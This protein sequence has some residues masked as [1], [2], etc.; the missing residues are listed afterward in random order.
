MVR[1][2]RSCSGFRI[3]LYRTSCE[4]Q[5]N[6]KK[7]AFSVV[8]RCLCEQVVM[9]AWARICSSPRR[10][11]S[12]CMCRRPTNLLVGTMILRQ[13]RQQQQHLLLLRLRRLLRRRLLLLLQ[14]LLLLLLLLLPPPPPRLLL[15]LLLLLLLS[16]LFLR[17]DHHTEL[18]ANSNNDPMLL[19]TAIVKCR[20]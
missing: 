16:Q 15:L 1:E 19:H 12:S 14:L 5:L 11:L 18:L 2:F 9:A 7:D 10:D 8:P 20:I 6:E 17:R 4:R 13:Q 3:D